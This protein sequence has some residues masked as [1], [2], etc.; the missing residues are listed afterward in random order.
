MNN[1][2]AHRNRVIVI[3]LFFLF[4]G[5]VYE[6]YSQS[7]TPDFTYTQNCEE[8]TF[9]NLSTPAGGLNIVGYSWNFGDLGTST[10]EN[11]VHTYAGDG[12][13]EVILTVF[14]DG[15][16]Q[17]QTSQI[18]SVWTPLAD[19]TS[20]EVCLGNLT[21]FTSTSTTPPNSTLTNWEWDFDNDGTFD[22]VGETVGFTYAAPGPKTVVLR[23]TNNLNCQNTTTQNVNVKPSPLADFTADVVCFGLPTNFSDA[24]STPNGTITD[25]RWDFDND[26]TFDAFVANP[27]FTFPNS[28]IFPVTL[29]IEN[30]LGCIHDTIKD[31][32]VFAGPEASFSI[33]PGCPLEVTAFTDE[34]T[35]GTAAINLW[36]WN[37]G[38]GSPVSTDQNPTHTYLAN[39]EFDVL[40]FVADENGCQDDTL[41]SLV[42]Q[43]PDAGF[44]VEDVCF[45]LPSQFDDTSTFT[46]GYPVVFWEWDFGDGGSSTDE[47][48]A[49]TYTNFGLFEAELIVG[50]ELSCFDTVTGTVLIDTLP[51]ASFTFDAACQGLPTCFTDLSVANSDTIVS[52]EWDFGDGSSSTLKDPC[53]IFLGGGDF[54][55][56]LTVVNS[57]GCISE[58]F[59]QTVFVSNAPEVNYSYNEICFGDT[60]YF[61]NLTDTFGFE[62][63]TLLWTFGDTASTSNSST[64]YNPFHIFSNPG[65]YDVKLFVG[66]VFGCTDSLVQTVVV[67]SIPEALFTMPDTISTGVTFQLTDQ[68]VSHGSPIF[69]WFWDFGDGTS[70]TNI[71]PITH[72]YNQTGDYI[73]CLTV[74]DFN[75]CS[76]QYCD[77]IFVIGPPDADFSYASDTTLETFFED[78]SLP[79]QN[80]VD[81]RWE[82]GDPTTTMDTISG[83]PNPMWEYPEQGWYNVFLRVEDKFGGIHDTTKLIYAGNAVLADFDQFGQCV[84][85]TTFFIDKSSSP[86]AS[87]F[88][89]WYWDFGD[90]TDTVYFEKIDTLMHFY[91]F[92]GNYLVR[93]AVSDTISGFFMTDTVT[94]IVSV[95]ESPVAK[96]DTAGLDVC[97]GQTIQF[98]DATA[99]ILDPIVAWVWDFDTPA[100]DSA[101]I[102]NPEFLYAD[103]GTYHVKM[104]VETGKGCTS[105]DTAIAHVNYAPQFDFIVE[106]N[107]IN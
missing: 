43:K 10:L 37:F 2:I 51:V 41:I 71:N 78:A 14:H 104:I 83:I 81:W 61:I 38:D 102:K 77:T 99:A 12:D 57:D 69:T 59:T 17:V 27:S 32:Q 47:D 91:T 53:H 76:S 8:V 26:G 100:G 21:E 46:A 101:F 63:D 16:G 30:S 89:R 64:L 80:I 35:A 60:T 18:V 74:T 20:S 28:G 49:Y 34:S 98:D 25:Y 4:G 92:P 48:P 1:N 29:E 106:N 87:E 54:E 6:S 75:G 73:V 62:I 88:D 67:D 31:I 55:V 5:W 105:T 19:F 13:F 33:V 56:S 65:Q 42:Q 23:V 79:A 9:Q 70:G 24:S 93:F 72:A 15:P 107:C 52:W 22:A 44:Q 39:G 96:I 66:N 95:F 90:G 84:G 58:A 103:T 45:G 68:S 40:L 85:D 7:V 94:R 97:F 50:N 82:F 3:L 11:P 86:L 36:E